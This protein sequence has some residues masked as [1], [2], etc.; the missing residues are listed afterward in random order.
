[1]STFEKRDCPRTGILPAC[2]S[3]LKSRCCSVTQP[4]RGWL[5]YRFNVSVLNTQQQAPDVLRH[6]QGTQSFPRTS[7][8]HL[9]P[10][11]LGKQRR[12][13]T[14]STVTPAPPPARRL[15]AP[16]PELKRQNKSKGDTTDV[17]HRFRQRRRATR[18]GYPL[19]PPPPLCGRIPVAVRCCKENNAR[20]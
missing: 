12:A 6:L 5:R 16:H 8:S 14:A 20:V 3:L 7:A 9:L 11:P 2:T 15:T 13:S 17:V 4:Q 18:T 1:M 10:N 19:P